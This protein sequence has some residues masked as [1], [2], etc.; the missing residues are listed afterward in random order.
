MI[1]LIYSAGLRRGELL[2]L[3]MEDINSKRMM[4]LIKI[5]KGQK[6]GWYYYRH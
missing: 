4:I 5:G 2:N 3:N 1:S 6:I